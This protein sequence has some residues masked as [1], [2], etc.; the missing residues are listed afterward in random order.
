MSMRYKLLGRTG[1]RV[2]ELCLGAM[3]VGDRRGGW[4]ATKDEAAGIVER[5]AEAGGNFID[6]A[7]SYAGGEGERIVD[8]GAVVTNVPMPTTPRHLYPGLITS[9]NEVGRQIGAHGH[10]VEHRRNAPPGPSSSRARNSTAASF[11]G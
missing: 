7:N 3:I 5:F 8:V 6:T 9:T 10:A 2:S 4:G 11:S 1:L